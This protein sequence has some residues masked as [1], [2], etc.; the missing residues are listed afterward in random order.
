MQPHGA[1]ALVYKDGSAETSIWENGIPVEFWTPEMKK[2]VPE[3][4][5]KKGKQKK[6]K[7][8]KPQVSPSYSLGQTSFN[9]SSTGSSINTYLPHL[10]LGEVGSP[11]DMTAGNSD[12]EKIGSLQMHDFAFI[13]RSDNQWTYAIIADKQEDTIRFVVDNDGSSKIISK[14]NWSAGIRL[15]NLHSK[16]K[17]KK[18]KKKRR[19]DIRRL[20]NLYESLNSS[21]TVS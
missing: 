14:K 6:K 20:S 5:F 2:I 15:V 13:L 21:S 4:Q 9:S 11:Q 18:K 19:S 10:D 12:P 3:V 17:K 1:G 16:L 7:K 8:K